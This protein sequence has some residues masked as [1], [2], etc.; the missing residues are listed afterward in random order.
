MN[1][2][3]CLYRIA[4][5]GFEHRVGAEQHPHDHPDDPSHAHAHTHA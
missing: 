1:C 2:D 4:L 3:T 5:P